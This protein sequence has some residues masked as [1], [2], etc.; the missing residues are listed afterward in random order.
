MLDVDEDYAPLLKA[1]KPSGCGSLMTVTKAEELQI[2]QSD[3]HLLFF[4]L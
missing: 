1:E 4:V 3:I 2:V